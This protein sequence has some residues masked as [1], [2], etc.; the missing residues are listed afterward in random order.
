MNEA[1]H[2]IAIPSSIC[3]FLILMHDVS[4]NDSSTIQGTVPAIKNIWEMFVS[5]ICTFK[6]E[7]NNMA[8]QRTV[9]E[10]VQAAWPGVT[11]FLCVL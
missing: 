2:F 10:R 3:L 5:K 11:F 7:S 9:W 6:F 1:H 4:G 8:T